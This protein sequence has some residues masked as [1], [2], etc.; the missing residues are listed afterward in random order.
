MNRRTILSTTV[1]GASTLSGCLSM[2]P[3]LDSDTPL[4]KAPTGAWTQYGADGT[5]TFAT[6]AS[7]PPRG[8]LAWTSEAFTRW[9]PVVSD[10]T[11]YLTN[12]DPSND[13]SAIALDAQDG[14]EQWRTTL[15]A[16]GDHGTVVVDDRFL[17][18]YDTELV[19]LDPQ[20]GEEIWT[21]RTNGIDSTELLVADEATGTVL[22]ASESGIEAFSAADGEK[23]WD[24]DTVRQLVRAPA[25]SDGRVFAVGNVDAAPSLVALS[26]EDGSERWRREFTSTP[27]SAAPVA[28]KE[29]VVVVDDRTLVVYNEATGDRLRELHSFDES[30]DP[31][32][33]AAA[34]GTVFVTTASGVV[35]VDVETGAE[36]W[37]R[38]VPV[39][40]VA[41]ICVGTETVVL[42]VDDPDFASG[43]ITISAFDRKSG[44]LR[45]YYGF[46]PGFHHQVTSPPVLVDGAVFFTATHIDGLGALG[47]VPERDS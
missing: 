34:D 7:A 36:R 29:G 20:M 3:S 28:T 1:V 37:R 41:G 40:Y 5:N 9:Q 26:L 35:A 15:N 45:W 30:E 13:G 2:L 42:P 12:F 4:P 8:N 10:G 39:S 46:D 6:N 22:V 23:H 31:Q 44:E 21:E 24:I 27:G 14:T 32:T 38:D 33:V 25:V 18:A 17:V 16:S 11:V 19:A 47:D 43:E